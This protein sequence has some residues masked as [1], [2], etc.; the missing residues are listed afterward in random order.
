[1]YQLYTCYCNKHE[2]P[3][4]VTV[5]GNFGGTDTDSVTHD[6][7]VTT[8]NR[9]FLNHQHKDFEF[10]GPDRNPVKIVTI[11]QCIEIAD[12]I[13]STE[14]PNYVKARFSIHSGLNLEAWEKYLDGYHDPLLLQY[15]KFGFTLSILQPDC[16]NNIDSP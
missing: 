2:Y 3:H 6:I 5:L 15:L 12:M 10:I 16:L 4:L 9:G 8:K 7:N 11:D 14:V 13:R 1:M